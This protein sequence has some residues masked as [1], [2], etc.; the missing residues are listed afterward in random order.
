MITVFG[1][2]LIPSTP[3]PST[4]LAV[5][6]ASEQTLKHCEQLFGSDLLV[7]YIP[8]SSVTWKNSSLW[9]HLNTPV[10]CCCQTWLVRDITSDIIYKEVAL[11]LPKFPWPP[12]HWHF[13]HHR[14]P[15]EVMNTATLTQHWHTTDSLVR[16]QCVLV[17][18]PES[19]HIYSFSVLEDVN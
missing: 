6:L 16:S 8:T 17:N 5:A 18:L 13:R 11:L 2:L 19:H 7:K 1:H 10:T 12:P 3:S 14:N 9:A 15:L 4:A